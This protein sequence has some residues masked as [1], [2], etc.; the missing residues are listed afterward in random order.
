MIVCVSYFFF[1]APVGKEAAVLPWEVR[2]KV[3]VGIA[4]ALE[5]LH[6]GCTRPVIHRDVKTSNI[7]L[8]ANFDSQVHI[9]LQ[10]HTSKFIIVTFYVNNVG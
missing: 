5:H 8:T 1:T 6:Q 4:R 2:H 7:L 10:N 3:A 9:F